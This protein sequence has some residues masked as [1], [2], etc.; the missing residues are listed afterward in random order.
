MRAGV[1]RHPACGGTNHR[2][3]TS[4]NLLQKELDDQQRRYDAGTVPHFNVLRARVSLANARPP[5][6][7]A[8]NNYRIAKNNLSNLL[9]YNLPRDIWD[10]IPLKLTDTL[11]ATTFPI[12]LP[13]ALQ[14]AL[15]KRPELLALR[16]RRNCRTSI[17]RTHHPVTNPTSSFLPV[18]TGST[19]NL[20]PRPS[21]RPAPDSRPG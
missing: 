17:S 21:V 2:E 5:L 8:Q 10:N 9:G 13:E 12:N 11:D 3:Q 15:D 4:V 7:Q 19:N 1:L 20:T 14:Q 18:T 16:K 6:I